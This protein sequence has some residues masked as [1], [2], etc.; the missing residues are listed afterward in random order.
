MSN[1]PLIPAQERFL[2]SMLANGPVRMFPGDTRMAIEWPSGLKE[3]YRAIDRFLEQRGL[4]ER[5]QDSE[6]TMLRLTDAGRAKAEEL[7]GSG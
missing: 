4:T 1:P 6:N 2:K 5:Y 3:S 7:N